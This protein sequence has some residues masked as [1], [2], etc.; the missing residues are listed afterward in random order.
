MGDDSNNY[1]YGWIEEPGWG[2][3]GLED[4]PVVDIVRF[5]KI[6]KYKEEFLSY[7]E[8]NSV[9]LTDNW[10]DDILAKYSLVN[11][12]KDRKLSQTAIDLLD[13]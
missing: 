10:L 4:G 12:L 7:D 11:K 5:D 1:E 2:K 8:G 6:Q 3:I 9:W 13:I